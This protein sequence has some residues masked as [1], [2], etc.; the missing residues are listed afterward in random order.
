[1]LES[2]RLSQW[3]NDSIIKGLKF[4][5]ALSVHGYKF[6]RSTGYPLPSYSTLMRKIQDVKLTF[7]I[8]SDVIDLLKFKVESMCESDRFCVLSYDEMVVSEQLDFDKNLGKFTGFVTLGDKIDVLGQKI[9]TVVVRGIKNRWKQVI[10]CH[11][12][13]KQH[14]DPEV[15]KR[16]MLECI[17]SVENCGLHVLALSSDLDGRNRSLWATLNI[18]IAKFGV[19]NNSFTFNEHEIFAIPDAC[20]LLKNL[21]A[22]VLRQ[23]IYLPTSYTEVE[24]LP[25]NEVDGSYVKQLWDH[26]IAHGFEKRLLHHIRQAD[27]EPSNFDKMNVG[28]AVRFFSAKTASALQTAVANGILPTKA[29]TTSHFILIIEKWFSI[30]SSKVRKTSIT[31]RN[32]D[33]KYIFLH[34]IIDLFQRCVFKEGWKP[35]NYGFVLCT[36]SFCDMVEFLFQNKYDFVLGHRFTQDVTENVFSQIRNKE[37]S[38]PSAQKA[39]RAIRNITVA[40]YVSNVKRTNYFNDSDEFLL[41]FCETKK[42]SLQTSG[43]PE[44]MAHSRSVHSSSSAVEFDVKTLSFESFG[45]LFSNYDANSTFFIAGST[46]KALVPHVC[47]QC[48]DFLS[49]KNLP[50]SVYIQKAKAYT[51]G[52]DKGG[53]REPCFETLNLILHCEYYYKIYRDHILRNENSTLIQCLVKNVNIVFP[54]CCEVKEKIVKHYFTVRSFCVKNFSENSKK[55]KTVFGTASAKRTKN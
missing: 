8:F 1:M 24:E 48:V 12:T 4:R 2:G 51:K 17:T 44:N 27:V 21:K 5:F 30:I 15:L 29:L 19:R 45:E 49:L 32:C 11:I 41:N 18:N 20:H 43:T 28:A 22:A 50:E 10:A 26:E 55:R 7:G 3:A 36:L 37:G 6:L 33:Q 35:L 23:I 53:L 42:K 13:H 9:F 47:P 34:M 52:A 31:S 38:M 39:L 40:Q 25:S 46:T 14:I 54:L 16:F